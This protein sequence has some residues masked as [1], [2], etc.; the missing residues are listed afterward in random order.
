LSGKLSI[1]EATQHPDLFARWFKDRDTWQAWIAF[2]RVMFG[3]PLDDEQ[4][5]I[6]RKHTGRKLPAPGGYFDVSLVVGRRGGKSIILALIGTYLAAL[7]DW[8]QYL[9]DGERGV[10]M[11][12]AADRRQAAVALRYIKAFLSI[13]LLAG[14]IERETL[15]TIEL[16]NGV[17]IEVATASYKTVRG[18]TIL[19]AIADELAFWSDENSQNPDVEII[20]ALKPAMATIPGA[21]L[22]KASSPYARRGVLWSDYRKHYGVD[23]SRTVV[24]KASTRDM[25]PSVPQSFIDEQFANDPAS[26]AAEYGAEFRTDVEAFLTREAVEAVVPRGRLE[27][28]PTAGVSYVGFVDPSGGSADSMTLAIA[29]MDGDLAVLDLVREVRPPFS[30]ESVVTEF[31]E[32]LKRYGIAQVSGDRYG[33]E[34][35]RERFRHHDIEYATSEKNK[36][37][38]YQ[39]PS[40]LINSGRCELLDQPRIIGQICSLERR[41]AR[42]GRDSID[43]PPGQHDDLANVV[44]GALTS[45]EAPT[46]MNCIMIGLG[47]ILGHRD[48]DLSVEENYEEAEA[49]ASRGELKGAQLRWFLNERRRRAGKQ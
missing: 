13:P 37:E 3:L 8:S 10:V 38:L 41:T 33:G 30:P 26:A 24:W 29:H 4:L 40:P 48:E 6:F 9:V 44:A 2:L 27:I 21:R 47:A 20:N 49:A 31:A 16:G 46:F 14:L 19:A 35:P 18:R 42:S 32:V 34:W 7:C 45:C 36:S 11:V 28:M 25:N 15:D 23:D 1:I 22:L 17:T 12:L 43:H 39:A 5:A